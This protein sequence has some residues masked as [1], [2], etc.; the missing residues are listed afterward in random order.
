MWRAKNI[1]ILNLTRAVSDEQEASGNWDDIYMNTNG[2]YIRLSNNRKMMAVS[3]NLEEDKIEVEM[4][5][6]RTYIEVVVAVNAKE[7]NNAI[8]TLHDNA[9][10]KLVASSQRQ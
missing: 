7:L 8:N 1:E 6:D 9:M 10:T 3:I 2:C 4:C 5:H